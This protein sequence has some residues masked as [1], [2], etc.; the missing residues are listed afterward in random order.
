MWAALT[1][2]H[3][4]L[5]AYERLG[6][7]GFRLPRR[8]PAELRD[9][10][11]SE[12]SEYCRL[13]PHDESELPKSMD[14]LKRRYQ[15]Y[16][17]LFGVTRT[18]PIIPDTGRDFHKLWM[19]SIKKNYHPSQ[20]K[21]KIQLLFQEGLFKLLAMAAVSGKAQKNSGISPGKEKII[22]ASRVALL[23]LVWL[24]QKPPIER[25]FLRMMWGPDA[26]E[27]VN[28][29]RKL[30]AEATNKPSFA[31]LPSASVPGIDGHSYTRKLFAD[32]HQR[33]DHYEQ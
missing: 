20:R 19:D 12:V 7:H 15:K 16:D 32:P 8:L 23:P 33:A 4:M 5:W 25:Y 21:V 24:L 3:S 1:E 2:M 31:D 6:F 13:F 28:A 14:D 29:A 27:L 11:I 17:K 10:Y 9:R 26:V 22:L 30:H 18:L